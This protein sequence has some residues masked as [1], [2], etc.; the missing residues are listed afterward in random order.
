VAIGRAIV[1]EPK[2]FL[3][4]EPLSNLD[5]ELRVKMRSEIVRLHRRL[6]STVVYVTHDQVEAMTM[7]DRIV[8]LRDGVTEQIGT[9]IELY[10]RPRNRFVAGF[11]G[12]PQMNM[13]AG[14]IRGTGA[15][16]VRAEVDRGRS[17]VPASVGT[18]ALTVGEKCTIGIRPEHLLPAD[19]GELRTTVAATEMVGADTLVYATLQSG[20]RVIASIRGIHPIGEG[21]PLAFAIDQR[22]V[23]VF[24]ADDLALAPL[25]PWRDDYVSRLSTAGSVASAPRGEPAELGMRVG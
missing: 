1:K 13:L 19:D 25:R 5:A 24:G 6:Q 22:F 3:F 7:A 16:G 18:S 14:V 2:A 11:L 8:V 12:A 9:P 17:V 20:E 10:A 15:A 23:H 21:S 4:D